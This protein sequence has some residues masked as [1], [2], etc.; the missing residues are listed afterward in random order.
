MS[1]NPEQP[2]QLPT[3]DFVSTEELIRR[4]GAHPIGSVTEL[5][6]AE[7]PFES[8]QEFEDF[9]TDLYATRR[10]DIA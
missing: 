10:A 1:T 4:H 7:D 9:L 3:D 8:D 5:A 6:A 2:D